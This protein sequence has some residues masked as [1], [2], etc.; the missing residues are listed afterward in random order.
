ME[1]KHRH[2][3]DETLS[4]IV[5]ERLTVR[6]KDVAREAQRWT[7]G[8]RGPIIDDARKIGTKLSQPGDV[9]LSTKGTVGRVAL[10]PEGAEQVVYSPQ[11]CYFRVRDTEVLHPRYLAYWFKSPSF[12]GQASYRANSTDMAPYI[13]L[14]DI[15]SLMMC[16]PDIRD[17][18][19]VA[20]VLGALDDKIAV[21]DL[22][23]QIA[24]N[25]LGAMFDRI[26]AGS[27]WAELSTIGAV[28]RA[29]TNPVPGGQLR[30]V[31]ISSVGRGFF[32]FPE[33]MPWN[34]CAWPCATSAF[35]WRHRV[36]DRPAQS[37]IA[38]TCARR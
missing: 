9:L 12:A 26:R 8:E 19:A 32:D 36:V 25:F 30:Y 16:L 18:Y 13:S 14:C 35:Q 4:A 33:T 29:V 28:N 1:N 34:R 24:D 38:R 5:I 10:Y 17:Q 23:R 31:D 11:L 20:E 27:T 7:T 21:N 2:A 6:D 3:L 37:T 15:R 22:I